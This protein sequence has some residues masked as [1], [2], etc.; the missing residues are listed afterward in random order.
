MTELDTR[1]V[2]QTVRI[3]ARPETVWSFWTDPELLREWWGPASG[4]D[5]QP[6][7]AYRIAMEHGPVIR[8]E[9]VELVPYE[10]IVFSFGWE[11][12]E[13]RPEMGPGSTRVE[14]TLVPDGP[15]TVLT[16]RHSDVPAR[17][18]SEHGEGWGHHLALLASA[19]T[20]K[21]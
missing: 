1:V 7:G 13:G 6:G 4:F 15:D 14:V 20:H 9:F 2:E 8:G 21:G 11:P 17:Y 18:T 12:G 3:A 5:P 10:R 16:L 19:V